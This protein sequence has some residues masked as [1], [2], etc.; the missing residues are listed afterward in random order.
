MNNR[1]KWLSVMLCLCLLGSFFTP[2]R[3]EET[4]ETEPVEEVQTVQLEIATAE[5]FLAFAENCRLDSYSFHLAVTLEAD[6]DLSGLDFQGIPTFSGSFDGNGH[7]ISGLNVTVEGSVLGLFRYL[8][9]GAQVCNL[10]V[11]GCVTPAGSAAAVGGIAGSNAGTIENCAFEGTVA[12]S[13]DVGG[14]A[15]IN[16][17]T[18]LIESC[19]IKGSIVGNHFVGGVAGENRGVIRDCSNSAGI[20]TTAAQNTVDLSDI[21]LDTLTG[22]E[23]ANTVTD[24]GGIAGESSGVIRSCENWGNV[25]YQHMGYNIGGIAGTQSGYIVDCVNYGKIDGR[26]E[27]GG[28]A[29]QMEPVTNITYSEDTLQILQEQAGTLQALTTRAS[30]NAQSNAANVNGQVG[31]LQDQVQTVRDS[32][33]VLIPDPE[34]PEIPDMDSIQAAQNNLT[35]SLSAMPGTLNRLSASIQGTVGTMAKDLQAISNQVGA[36]SATINDASEN[37]GMTLTDISDN[38]TAEDLTGKVENCR[39]HGTVL[40]DI[41]AG[42]I[43]GA[44]AMENDLDTASDLELIG[45]YSMNFAG[46]IRAVI[47]NCENTAQVTVK[48]QYGGGIVGGQL[49]GLVKDSRNTGAVNAQGAD[50]AGGVSGIS[51]GFIRGC[52]VKCAIEADEYVGGVAG[53]GQTVSDCRVMAKISGTEKTGAVLGTAEELPGETQEQKIQNNVYLSVG[54]D[55]GAVD[56][57]SYDGCAQPLDH[58]AFFA[59]EDLA[60]ILSSVILRFVFEDGSE[61]LI[62]VAPGSA[63]DASAIPAVPEKESYTGY[64][65]GLDSLDLSNVCF[66]ERFTLSYIRDLAVIESSQ[67]D[68][69]G[70]PMLLAQGQFT[71][72]D[73]LTF[74]EQE[75]PA[76]AEGETV[77]LSYQVSAGDGNVRQLRVLLREDPSDLRLLLRSSEG[78]WTKMEFTQD[79]S[80]MVFAVSEDTQGFCF[81]KKAPDYTQLRIIV[82]VLA[83]VLLAAAA[84]RLLGKKKK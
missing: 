60:Q 44:I 51:T 6:I 43:A 83:V 23:S 57:I 16:T 27:V 35:S 33:D 76:L 68:E 20:N 45:D 56:G 64:W 62:S 46:E 31:L 37:M 55:I 78:A 9:P 17:L 66:D 49:M 39:N 7:V 34:N 69:T 58:D 75:A 22:S 10:M 30:T 3:A 82:A 81:V 25:G 41:N 5:E 52:S 53:Q 71:E 12:G 40:A 36:M 2:V 11:R 50:Y 47:L 32:V 26:K 48:K 54:T 4:D 80:Y 15:G 38:D 67:T 72:K 24:I 21:T 42:G 19:V 1:R 61:Q 29:G 28:I 14:I 8:Q 18:G 79:E 74:A 65:E 59:L 13:D 77:A 63:L 73:A 84:A 70:R